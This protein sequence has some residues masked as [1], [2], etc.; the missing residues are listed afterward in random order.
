MAIVVVLN[1]CRWSGFRASIGKGLPE[2]PDEIVAGRDRRIECLL[3]GPHDRVDQA[4]EVRIYERSDGVALTTG[5]VDYAMGGRSKSVIGPAREQIADVD[6]VGILDW[7]CRDPIAMS[8]LD[9]KPA[10]HV[11]TQQRQ[12]A[13]VR[14]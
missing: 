10:D 7:V 4:V 6:D 11:L 3:S 12:R 8:V 5:A 9:L 14:M 2:A 1:A 13:E